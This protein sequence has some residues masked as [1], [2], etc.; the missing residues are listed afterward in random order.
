MTRDVKVRLNESD[1]LYRM[2]SKKART[3]LTSGGVEPVLDGAGG[4]HS[5]FAKALLEALEKNTVYR[6]ENAR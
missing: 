1:Y 4:K 5:V 3:V 6:I 2:T